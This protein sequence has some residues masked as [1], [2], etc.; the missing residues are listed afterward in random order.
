[1]PAKILLNVSARRVTMG[2]FAQRRLSE[3]QSFP[4]DER[5]WA[6]FGNLL[7]AHERTPVYLMADVVEEDFRAET[8]PHVLGRARREMVARKL[9]QFFRTAPY[10]AAWRQGRSGNPSGARRRD[11]QYLFLALNS[12]D[13]LRPYL[14]MI[15]ARRAPLA[16]IYLLPVTSQALVERLGPRAPGVLLVSLQGGGLRQSFFVDGKL[17]ISRLTPFEVAPGQSLG[18]LL[19]DEIEK[20]RLFLYNARLFSRDAPLQAWIL[21]PAGT[22]QAAADELGTEVNFSWNVL[23]RDALAK[24]FGMP[25]ADL[26]QDMDALLLCLLG[27]HPPE[28]SLAQPRQ[29]RGFAYHQLRHG[30]HGL[31]ASLALIAVAWSGY[32]LYARGDHQERALRARK[33]AAQLQAQYE[34]AARGFPAAPASAENMRAAVEVVQQLRAHARTPEAAMR[35]IGQVLLAY[36]NVEL[37][38]LA[39]HYGPDKDRV[40]GGAPGTEAGFAGWQE[41]A[42]VGAE[43]RPFNGD[44]REALRLIEHLA[45]S[46]RAQPG[47]AEVRVVELPVNLDPKAGL[48]G[49]TSD[50]PEAGGGA[51]FK[52]ALKLGGAG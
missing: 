3:V 6:A 27:R 13:L 47:V 24:A 49:N 12:G 31:A 37:S 44:Y 50:S 17:R 10:R 5:A 48:S 28:C 2:V 30:L 15:E 46:L 21:D 7:A 8:L 29:T 23:G 39:W 42:V 43:I 41:T 4:A 1:M 40:A 52:L 9:G 14:E 20:S 34:D 18:R 19:A 36:P 38:R 51:Q 11:D 16:G 22:L 45:Q 35:A 32:N 26:P 25:A 33:D